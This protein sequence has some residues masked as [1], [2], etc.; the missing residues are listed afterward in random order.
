MKKRSDNEMKKKDDAK[1]T[2]KKS[3]EEL[4]KSFVKKG[5][6][7]ANAVSTAEQMRE[8]LHDIETGNVKDDEKSYQLTPK[9]ILWSELDNAYKIGG[10][11]KKFENF[12]AKVLEKLSLLASSGENPKL[13]GRD[14]NDFFMLFV[15]SLNL[16]GKLKEVL[17]ENNIDFDVDEYFRNIEEDDDDDEDDDD[18]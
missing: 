14:F 13:L 4:L 5:K 8:K 10:D 12:I 17:D 6:G 11:L 15:K 18:E 16:A 2:K 1:S 3:R 7:A 9:G